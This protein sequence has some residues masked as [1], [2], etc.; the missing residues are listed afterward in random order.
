MKILKKNKLE[1]LLYVF[2][3][4][5]PILDALAFLVREWFPSLVISPI[6]VVRFLIPLFILCYIFFK[7]NGARK[8]LFIMFLVILVYDCCHLLIFKNNVKGIA[9]GGIFQECQ[10]LLNYSYMVFLLF[11]VLYLHKKVGLANLKKALFIMLCVYL[12]IIYFSIITGTSYS[13]YLEGMGYRGYFSSGNSIGTILIILYG[14]L[15]DDLRKGGLFYKIV[16][17]LLLIYLCFLLGTRTGLFGFVLVSLVYVVCLVVYNLWKKKK[18][19]FKCIAISFSVLFVVGCLFLVFGS[20]TI[21]RRNHLENEN[22]GVIDINTGS[23]GHTSGDTSAMVYKIKNDELSDDYISDVEAVSYLKMYDYA[24]EKNFKGTDLRRQQMVFHFHLF[25]EQKSI[26]KVLF[27][28][29]YVNH[30]GEMIL[31][32]EILAFLFNFGVIGFL[33]FLGSFVVCFV[34]KMSKYRE[35]VNKDINLI[36]RSFCFLLGLGLALMAGYVFFSTSCIL[37]MICNLTL[38]G[39]E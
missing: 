5:S 23:L 36:I 17:G 22:N 4:I 27:G 28:N 35:Y 38:L 33:V 34:K 9:Y 26:T 21:K 2:I 20:E 10:Y 29:G 18:I 14:T 12:V 19:S 11:M 13:T 7:D 24:N 16:W 39:G 1:Y 3:I 32:S 6:M 37:V 8:K 30:Y 31:E 25:K 15:I